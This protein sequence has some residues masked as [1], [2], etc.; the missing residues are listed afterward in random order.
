MEKMPWMHAVIKGAGEEMESWACF[1]RKILIYKRANGEARHCDLLKMIVQEYSPD[2]NTVTVSSGPQ[3]DWSKLGNSAVDFPK[4]MIKMF[5]DA[6]EKVVQETGRY[7][8]KDVTIFKM[9]AS[10]GGMDMRVEMTVDPKQNILLCL[11]QRAF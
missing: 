1:E 8:D 10:M 6:G 7:L 9:S 3:L 5:E 2:A 11:N 4:M